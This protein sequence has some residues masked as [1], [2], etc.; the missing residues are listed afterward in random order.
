LVQR[1]ENQIDCF[2]A[3][4]AKDDGHASNLDLIDASINQARKMIE[5]LAGF[6]ES[7]VRNL[8]AGLQELLKKREDLVA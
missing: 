3:A 1:V 5:A 8:N 6:D 7:L 4:I 2:G